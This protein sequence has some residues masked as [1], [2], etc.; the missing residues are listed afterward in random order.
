M[1]FCDNTPALYYN[2]SPIFKC[3]CNN[4]GYK[5]GADNFGLLSY[6]RIIEAFKFAYAQRLQLGDPDFNNTIDEVSEVM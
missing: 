1:L 6:H 4:V 2:F 3:L 5:F